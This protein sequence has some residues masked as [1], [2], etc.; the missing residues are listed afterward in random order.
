M[1]I[2]DQVSNSSHELRS[3]ATGTNSVS[4]TDTFLTVAKNSYGAGDLVEKTFSVQYAKDPANPSWDNDPAMKLY[5]QVMTKY[6][7]KGRV[8]DAL[9]Y[10]GV[11]TAHAFVQLL[12]DAGKNTTRDS[13]MKAYRSWNEAN[14][15]LLPGI[16]Q[17]TGVSGQFP[18]KCDQ[19]VKF[20]N[21]T[22]QPV[23]ATKCATTGT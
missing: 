3:S 21:G 17:R 7:P 13:L 6:Y 11:A 23:S 5:K 16:K 14:P 1:Q 9:N 8:T 22:F 20:T 4:A 15:F 19:V 18:L 10:Y 2:C 12:Y